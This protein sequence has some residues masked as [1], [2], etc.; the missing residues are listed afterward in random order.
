MVDPFVAGLDA[1]ALVVARQI[2][3]YVG[4]NPDAADT[5]AGIVRW[6]L[7]Q[8]AV[9]DSELVHRTLDVLVASGL[10]ESRRLPSGESLYGVGVKHQQGH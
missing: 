4:R 1:E 6:W 5:C 7:P 8:G 2:V 3:D 9:M 10:L